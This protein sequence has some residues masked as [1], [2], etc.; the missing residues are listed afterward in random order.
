M[1]TRKT[2][3]DFSIFFEPNHAWGNVTGQ[4]ILGSDAKTSKVV[5]LAGDISEL[6]SLGI[7]MQMKI[8]SRH[9]LVDELG[10][11]YSLLIL[12]DVLLRSKDD[13]NRMVSAL[14]KHLNLTGDEYD[15]Q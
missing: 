10:E 14:E 15:V 9:E 4:I 5:D 11:H 12:E 6:K 3:I 7:P 13:A 2:Y 1:K 8:K